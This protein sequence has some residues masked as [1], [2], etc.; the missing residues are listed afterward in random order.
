M[1]SGGAHSEAKFWWFVAAVVRTYTHSMSVCMYV[2]TCIQVFHVRVY[3]CTEIIH[4]YSVECD[5]S[6]LQW[7]VCILSNFTFYVFTSTFTCTRVCVY[8]CVDIS[9]IYSAVW[10]CSWLQWYVNILSL[11][12]C[13][14]VYIYTHIRS[15]TSVHMRTCHTFI[16]DIFSHVRYKFLCIYIIHLTYVHIL[17]MRTYMQY[18]FTYTA[19]Y[20]WKFIMNQFIMNVWHI[21]NI[22]TYIHS[23]VSD[24]SCL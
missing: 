20:D 11:N 21:F 24:Y 8:M 3:I 23:A 12:T 22:C 17:Y 13:M 9:Y 15:F 5:S 7:N 18:V 19:V 1:L 14:C 16:M 4:I 6:W 2:L 10:D